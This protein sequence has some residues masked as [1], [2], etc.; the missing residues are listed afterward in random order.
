MQRS[1]AVPAGSSGERPA[2]TSTPAVAA[3]SSGSWHHL[4]KVRVAG[5]SPVVRSNVTVRQRPFG[6]QNPHGTVTSTSEDQAPLIDPVQC[7]NVQGNAA[8]IGFERGPSLAFLLRVQDLGEGEDRLGVTS[9]PH[10]PVCPAPEPFIANLGIISGDIVVHDARPTPTST[11]QCKAGGW[12][13]PVDDE[14]QPF[15]NQGQCVSFVVRASHAA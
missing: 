5:S 10:P 14:G 11:A 1:P 6:P 9:H 15:K 4:A 7:L 8:T 12:R 3:V 2:P 13:N